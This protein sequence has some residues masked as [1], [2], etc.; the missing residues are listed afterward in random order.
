MRVNPRRISASVVSYPA[1]RLFSTTL[2]TSRSGTSRSSST[3]GMFWRAMSRMISSAPSHGTTIRPSMP[4]LR[5]TSTRFSNFCGFSSV[6]PNSTVYLCLYAWFSM[7]RAMSA[8]NLFEMS[9]TMTPMVF[10]LPLRRVRAA[11]L[12][13]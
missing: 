12:G 2:L 11:L 5:K 10:V 9:E 4:L 7:H 6:L 3:S 1:R 8:K 13:W